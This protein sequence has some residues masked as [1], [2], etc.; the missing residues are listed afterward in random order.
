MQ[1]NKIALK[2]SVRGGVSCFYFEGDKREGES[3]EPSDVEVSK[4]EK[5]SDLEI[6]VIKT[7]GD[8]D[9]KI[10]KIS[11]EKSESNQ[12]DVDRNQIGHP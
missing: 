10:S 3:L 9:V 5:G 7:R 11:S 6:L 2:T 12:T 8:V 1:V 4:L